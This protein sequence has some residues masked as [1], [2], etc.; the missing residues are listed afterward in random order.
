MPDL[1]TERLVIR[2]FTMDDF[3]AWAGPDG[4]APED[5][6]EG[7]DPTEWFEWAVRNYDALAQLGQ[8]PYGDR[9]VALLDTGQL[10]GSVGFVP[11]FFALELLR[12]F[13][14]TDEPPTHVCSTPE[15][16][17]FYAFGEEYRGRGYATEAVRAMVDYAF[18]VLNVKRIVCNTGRDN[19][20]SAR[21]M[22]RIGM[23]VFRNASGHPPRMDVIGVLE[24]PSPAPADSVGF[25]IG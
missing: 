9:A 13:R 18:R 6:F 7:G 4:C 16:G 12:H 11:T 22:E 8:P 25:C 15:F 21:M 23:T 3:D 17:V 20:A 1:T 2:P 24:N 10:I 19:T 5:A 14:D